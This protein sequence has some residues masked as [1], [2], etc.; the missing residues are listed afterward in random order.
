MIGYL[1]VISKNI[2]ISLFGHFSKES[3]PI[4][5]YE[6]CVYSLTLKKGTSILG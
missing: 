3:I 1:A 4:F 2:S 5:F 6:K